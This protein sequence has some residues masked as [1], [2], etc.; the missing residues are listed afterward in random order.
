METLAFVAKGMVIS[1]STEDS[2]RSGE[3]KQLTG[4]EG[5]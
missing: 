1:I 2:R 4:R 3:E 5:T